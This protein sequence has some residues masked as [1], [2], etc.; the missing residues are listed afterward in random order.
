MLRVMTMLTQRGRAAG[1]AMAVLVTVA[2]AGAQADGRPFAGPRP[3]ADP[4]AGHPSAAPPRQPT[5]PNGAAPAGEPPA[6]SEYDPAAD[7]DPAALQDF[8]ARSSVWIVRGGLAPTAPFGCREAA[9][10]APTSRPTSATGTGHSVLTAH[11]SGSA[12]SAGAGRPSITGDGSG[13]AAGAGV[14][15]PAGSIPRRGSSGEPAFTTTLTSAGPPCRPLGTARLGHGLAVSW[16]LTCSASA[17]YVFAVRARTSRRRYVGYIAPRTRP[18]VRRSHRFFGGTER[19]EDL[20][21]AW[22]RPTFPGIRA[23]AARPPD[24]RRSFRARMLTAALV[25]KPQAGRS[26]A[27]R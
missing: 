16:R 18:Y 11:G 7:R 21:G 17:T 9:S 6:P 10:S 3:G 2:A 25:R 22:S 5:A 4:F 23:G 13:S 1:W 15:F 12:T 8:Q 26:P 19:R 27:G 24:P 14:G 20:I